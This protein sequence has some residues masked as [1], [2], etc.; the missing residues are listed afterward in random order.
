MSGLFDLRVD[1]GRWIVEG[2]RGREALG[3]APRFE[4][5][6]RPPAG[7][8]AALGAVAELSWPLDEGG[9]R[10]VR[11]QVDAVEERAEGSARGGA[12]VLR[13]A[14]RAG[15]LGDTCDHRVFLD[16]DA[17]AVASAVLSAHGIR[18]DARCARALPRRAQRVQRFESDL[19]FVSRILAEE[20][21]AWYAHPEEADVLVA[22]DHPA[23]Y[24]PLAGGPIPVR[25][26]SG[27]ITGRSVWAVRL[28]QRAVSDKVSL[29]DFDFQAPSHD[30]TVD[31]AVGGGRAERFEHRGGYRD[32]SLGRALAKIRLEEHRRGRV[33]LEGTTDARGLT[34]GRTIELEEGPV[35]GIAG[36]WIVTEVSHEGRERG[37][38]AAERPYEARF[39]A[40]PRGDGYRP[41]RAP[42]LAVGVQSMSVTG[43]KG[44]EIHTDAF[45]RSRAR[46]RWERE[47]PADDTSSAWLRSVQP[48]TS[49]GLFLPRV[50]WEVLTAF[51]HGSPDEP[52]ELGRLYTGV[53]PPPASLPGK[54]VVSAF[55]TRT[56][57][58]G[59]G[60]NGVTFDD[61]AG[62]EGMAFAAS[63][64]MNEK[65][66]KDKTAS[67]TANDT[68][69]VAASRTTLVGKV[70]EVKV[71]G[72][73][74]C[75]IGATR[76][77]NVN[78]NKIVSSASESLL[79]GGDRSFDVGGDSETEATALSRVVGADKIVAPIEHQS[80][81]V[82]GASRTLVTGAWMQ[83]AGRSA[84]VDVAG[85][86]LET[87][88]GA[89]LIKARSYGLTVKG[90]LL[91]S[92]AS[93][94]VEGGGTVTDGASSEERL[95]VGA[96]MNVKGF[97]VVF[98]AATRIQIQAGGVTL[99]ITPASVTISGR[100]D[101]AQGAKDDSSEDYD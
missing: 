27:L 94:S 78:A 39:S 74:T 24:E 95:D 70:C 68:L 14:A 88:F 63:R 100:F 98:V 31:A 36:A 89:K 30:L 58:G 56:T 85:V 34:P 21:V 75:W 40:V 69:S 50:G 65:T 90:A 81:L 1:G 28:R 73:Q 38:D 12:A 53:D 99:T 92:Y 79:I 45:G 22:T 43:P 61:T 84:A 42:R 52:L 51:V 77:L 23:G 6:A 62:N 86:S 16:E 59:G 37:A 9:E 15:A 18:L 97:S 26:P 47:R 83:R 5:L 66:E 80:Q 20:G 76:T 49:G 93:R 96:A 10:T 41:A 44:A 54:G 55:G 25:A 7:G 3:A 87:V 101:S 8:T 13:L 67:V 33:V 57:P 71:G 17:I 35:D 64:D 60:Q 11:A 48:P 2:L 32:P 4:V 46:F 29:R 19:S 72:A 91:E 82:T